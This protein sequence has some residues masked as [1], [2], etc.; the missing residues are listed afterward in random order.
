MTEVEEEKSV[1]LLQDGLLDFR[2][3]ACLV[4]CLKALFIADVRPCRKWYV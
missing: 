1:G 2:E 3:D 4:P